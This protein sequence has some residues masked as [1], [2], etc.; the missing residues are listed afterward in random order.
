MRASLTIEEP[1][2]RG[3]IRLAP[4]DLRMLYRQALGDCGLRAL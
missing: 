3:A 4:K 2:R 1:K